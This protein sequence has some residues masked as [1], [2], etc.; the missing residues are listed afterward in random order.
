M[1]FQLSLASR[2]PRETEGETTTTDRLTGIRDKVEKRLENARKEFSTTFSKDGADVSI[3]C[4]DGEKEFFKN[5]HFLQMIKERIHEA[6]DKVK[7]FVKDIRHS[8]SDT[9]KEAEKKE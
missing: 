1:Q 8:H 6:G 3:E 5:F 9:A 2:L 7:E 4:Y